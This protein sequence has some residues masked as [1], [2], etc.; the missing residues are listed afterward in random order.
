MGSTVH[1]R[2]FALGAGFVILMV[3]TAFWMREGLQSKA[4]AAP[5]Q[6]PAQAEPVAPRAAPTS[7]EYSN[8]VVAY[9]YDTIPITREELGEYL[10]ARFGNARLNSLVNRRIIEH[11]CREKGVEVSEA[12][13]EAELAA[14]IKPLGVVT[15]KDFETKVLK[16]QHTS[17]YEYK[18]DVIKPEL[19][20]KKLCR[21]RVQ[22]TD[23]DLHRAFE[24]YFGEKVDCRIII[25]PKN[26][27][28]IAMASYGKIRDNEDEFERASRSQASSRL[29]AT[30]GHIEPFG[31]NTT[32]NEALEKAAF[33]LRPGELSQVIETPEGYVVIKCIKHVPPDATKSPEAERDK[34]TREVIEKKLQAEIPRLFAELSKKAQ[35]KLLLGQVLTEAELTR[36]VDQLLQEGASKPGALPRPPGN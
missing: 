13:V 32:G 10:I 34:L 36:S 35:P 11:V 3:P 23:E 2:R 16:P 22:A 9:I 25:W 12:E 29:A 20:L 5:P 8:R 31:R 14:M 19:M 1:R 33:S 18:E 4:T 27:Y 24:A 21:D 30:G 17:L 6:T 15:L 7:S 26:E 28:K